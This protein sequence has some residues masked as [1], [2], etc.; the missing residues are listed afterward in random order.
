MPTVDKLIAWE[1]GEMTIAEE[2][3]FFQELVDNGSVWTLQGMYGRR[4]RQLIDAGYVKY[5]K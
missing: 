4:A 3:E 5:N 1:D 2:I